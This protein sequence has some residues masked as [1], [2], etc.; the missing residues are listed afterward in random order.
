MSSVTISRAILRG[1]VFESKLLLKCPNDIFANFGSILAGKNTCIDCF[2][3]TILEFDFC[4]AF[5]VSMILVTR[6]QEFFELGM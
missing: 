4:L 2:P 6:T 1:H 3:T 5:D